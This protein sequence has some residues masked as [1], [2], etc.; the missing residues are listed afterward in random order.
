LRQFGVEMYGFVAEKKIEIGSE[1]WPVWA[2]FWFC[3]RFL[4]WERGVFFV[5][6]NQVLVRLWALPFAFV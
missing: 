2:G 3:W 1:V 5:R 4:Y 6:V